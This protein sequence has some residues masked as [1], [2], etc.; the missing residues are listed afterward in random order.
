MIKDAD[1][2]PGSDLF[3]FNRASASVSATCSHLWID[4]TEAPIQRAPKSPIVGPGL[5][6]MTAGKSYAC[7]NC[8]QTL[9]ATTDD[10]TAKR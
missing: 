8:G 2:W 1:A 4:P 9:I 5:H 10:T 7:R 6:Q 3:G